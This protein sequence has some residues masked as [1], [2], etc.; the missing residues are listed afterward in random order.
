MKTPNGA[1]EDLAGSSHH[2]AYER[3]DD[4]E[5]R[6][7]RM[8]WLA[9]RDEDPP[10]RGLAELLAAAREKAEAMQVRPTLWQRVVA[11]LRRPPALAFA[12]VLVLVGGA[13]LLGRRGVEVSPPMQVA[14]PGA[15]GSAAS[16]AG[17][18]W[19]ASMR[20]SVDEISA[21]TPAVVASASASASVVGSPTPG[22]AV[23]KATARSGATTLPGGLARSGSVDESAANAEPPHAER[24]G[25]WRAADSAAIMTPR[26]VTAGK[27]SDGNEAGN[28][29]GDKAGNRA[30]DEAFRSSR[31]PAAPPAESNSKAALRGARPSEPAR[32]QALASDALAGAIGAAQNT[33][34][35]PPPPA[36]HEPAES[37]GSRNIMERTNAPTTKRDQQQASPAGPLA[38]LYE[39]C[40]AA[41][42]R[43]DC[44]AVRVMVGRITKADRS[45][46]ARIAKDSA[47]AKC[48]AE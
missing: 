28:E 38:Q 20:S 10:E 14:A 11:G 22:A 24:A 40:E 46:R 32:E 16:E 39:Q 48:L 35:V 41:A 7:M 27:D 26:V 6:S 42:R 9:M 4:L 19:P 29:A 36:A 31:L 33:P 18:A 47:V 1:P 44:V 5:L 23:A 37:S 3:D 15:A 2:D 45:Y 25:R 12:T 43:G 34:R 21:S 30:G 8:V 13:V 17:P